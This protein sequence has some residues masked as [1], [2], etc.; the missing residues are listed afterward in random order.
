MQYCRILSVDYVLHVHNGMPCGQ[1]NKVVAVDQPIIPSCEESWLILCDDGYGG[2]Q[3][4]GAAKSTLLLAIL[5]AEVV[6]GRA[7]GVS[8]A[9]VYQIG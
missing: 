1:L 4:L 6:G 5:G 3:W 8:L 9:G 7:A 2:L